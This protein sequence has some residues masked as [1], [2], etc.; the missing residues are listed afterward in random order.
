MRSNNQNRSGTQARSRKICFWGCLQINRR[1][2][3]MD[4]GWHGRQRRIRC[5][6]QEQFTTRRNA[7]LGQPGGLP[8]ISRGLSDHRERY[9]RYHDTHGSPP[10]RWW[11]KIRDSPAKYT[12]PGVAPERGSSNPQQR[13]L[14]RRLR[15]I[16]CAFWLVT[17]V[18]GR[19][20]EL[21]RAPGNSGACL[22]IMELARPPPSRGRRSASGPWLI[23]L[24]Q[25]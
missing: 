20:A 8:E 5:C 21:C 2:A 17:R 14:S 1:A 10:R 3:A 18:S 9:P 13:V 4:L 11:Q 16:L 22:Q 23:P 7:C 19:G 15:M 12:R 24:F 25:F 6:F